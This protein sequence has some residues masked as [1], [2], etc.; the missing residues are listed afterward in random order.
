MDQMPLPHDVHLQD[1]RRLIKEVKAEGKPT[2]HMHAESLADQF[3][4]LDVAMAWFNSEGAS[5]G[6]PAIDWWQSFF[7]DT[8]FSDGYFRLIPLTQEGAR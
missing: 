8:D 5:F 7:G 3:G 2:V 1:Y 4:S 6:P